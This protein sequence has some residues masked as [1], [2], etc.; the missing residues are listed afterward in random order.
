MKKKKEESKKSTIMLLK[1][2]IH[3]RDITLIVL[4]ENS[5][6]SDINYFDIK[7]N[8]IKK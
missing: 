5:E 4:D 6:L 1:K 3:N 8:Q 2:R 7:S